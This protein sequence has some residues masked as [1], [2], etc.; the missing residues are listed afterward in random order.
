MGVAVTASK[1]FADSV[2]TL[3]Q[4]ATAAIGL[5]D[6]GT[7]YLEGLTRLLQAFD[8][9]APFTPEGR[10]F[11][12]GAVVGTLI[13]RLYT[14][15]GWRENPKYRDTRICRPLVIIGIPR[16]GTTALH[17]LLAMDHQFQG[18]D[19]WLATS[20]MVRPPRD[21]WAHHPRYQA[22]V[23]NLTLFY[24]VMPQMRAAHEM[25]ADEVDE[26]YEVLKQNFIHNTFASMFQI[27]GYDEWMLA[28]D[29]RP[30]Y[31]RY[32]D[33]L[34]L[35]GSA[36]AGKPWL[37]KNP[38]HFWHLDLLFEVFPDAC[39]VQTHRDPVKAIPSV[40]SVLHM[41]RRISSGEATDPTLI[42]PRELNVS[43]N[44]IDRVMRV[45][46]RHKDQVI[47]VLHRDFHANPMHTVQQI[48]ERFGF[49]LTAAT[50]ARMNA[51]ISSN[52]LGKHGEHRYDLG[53]FGINEQA[54]RGRFKEYMETF[55]LSD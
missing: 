19:R 11:A 39:I 48:Y 27:P 28:Q 13:S 33:V 7:D 18:L 44:G 42:G 4:N 53:Q 40:C 45:R 41:T 10:E 37:L 49:K 46:Q 32:A 34:R 23:A 9:E 12:R 26:C 15:Q 5:A 2:A 1:N 50:E 25:A 36:D 22:E 47:D 21:T 8:T 54:I 55:S 20:P 30:N 43:G 24:G 6:F 16:T 51:W 38:C 17:R 31:R 35:I 14:Q 52:P 29:Q 3:H